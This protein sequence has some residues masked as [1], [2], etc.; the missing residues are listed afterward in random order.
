M[1][2]RRERTFGQWWDSTDEMVTLP[3]EAVRQFGLEALQAAGATSEGAEYIFN[4]QLEKALQGDHA[5]GLRNLPSIVRS[6]RRGDLDLNPDLRVLRETGATA[7]VDGGPKASPPLVGRFAMDLAIKK[8]RQNGVGWVAA[9][10]AGQILTPYVKQAVAANMIGMVTTQSFPNTAPTGGI[11]PILGNAPIAFGVPAGA[12]EPVILDMSMTQSSF[13]GVRMSALQG[14]KVPEG[15]I[16]DQHGEPT[17]DPRE[18]LKPEALTTEKYLVRGSMVPL[19]NSH[20]GYAMVFIVGLLSYVLTGTD[21]PWMLAHDLPRRGRYGSLYVA[22]DPAAFCPLDEL[23]SKV[24][25]FIDYLKASPK[26][27]GAAEILYPGEKSQRLQRE[28]VASGKIAIPRN[29]Y[30]A[31]AELAKELK[32]EGLP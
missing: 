2:Q 28:R 24:D 6:A 26:K 10:A 15:I 4:I 5:R 29:H 27:A 17:T 12:H 32:L 22:I 31:L 8:A 18:F 20:K 11:A 13:S 30:R 25:G 19:G 7:L 21:P 3:F 14:E 1:A 23:K 9:K 16:L